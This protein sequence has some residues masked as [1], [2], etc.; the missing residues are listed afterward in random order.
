MPTLSLYL[1]HYD[2]LSPEAYLRV[3]NNFSKPVTPQANIY[4]LGY[5]LLDILLKGKVCK[6]ADVRRGLTIRT[7][8]TS[9]ILKNYFN[10][11]VVEDSPFCRELISLISACLSENPRHRP[12]ASDILNVSFELFFY[13]NVNIIFLVLIF[14][15][16][17]DA[18]F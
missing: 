10:E 2:H 12:S 4:S 8:P 17:L 11:K 18:D 3:I 1:Q 15:F 13:Q 7:Y 16:V 9:N 14:N 6:V 5:L